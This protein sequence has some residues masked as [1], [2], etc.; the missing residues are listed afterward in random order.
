MK[1]LT[2]NLERLQKNRKEAILRIVENQHADILI[3][4]ETS[5]EINPGKEYHTIATENLESG[6]DGITYKAGENR[7]TIWTKYPIKTQRVTYDKFT[8]V[9]VD[10]ET[11]FGL[12]TIYGTII[13]V[14]GGKGE[15]F[16][17]D[18][19]KQSKDFVKLEGNICIAGDMNTTL[20]G[21]VYPSH[22]ARNKLKEIIQ[23]MDLCCPTASL[24]KNVDHILL[25]NSFVGNRK[26]G[27]T[28]WN[29]DLTLSD[30]IGICLSIE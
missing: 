13:G 18:F 29:E 28:L 7:T 20:S 19:E 8:S 4:T 5:S 22:D 23:R 14:F 25:S 2:W 3:L 16:K 10:V 9:C 27:V 15:R 24:D 1:I 11:E 17:N 12:L 26:I 21:Y 30:H 6:Y